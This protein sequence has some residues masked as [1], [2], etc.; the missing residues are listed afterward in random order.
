MM[1]IQTFQISNKLSA[2][3]L[4]FTSRLRSAIQNIPVHS[5]YSAHCNLKILEKEGSKTTILVLVWQSR[6]IGFRVLIN[7]VNLAAYNPR[8]ISC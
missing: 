1:Q 6:F 8:E 7:V 2:I 4:H 5:L 3:K